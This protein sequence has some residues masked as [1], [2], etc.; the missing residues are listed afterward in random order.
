M[1][2]IN[3]CLAQQRQERDIAEAAITSALKRFERETGLQ[4]VKLD[5][6]RHAEMIG[7]TRD[8]MACWITAE[9]PRR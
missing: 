9:L 8:L 1:P 4:V 2:P 5:L 7:G 3:P 6:V